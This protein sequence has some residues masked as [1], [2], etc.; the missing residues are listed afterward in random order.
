VSAVFELIVAV[1]LPTAAGFALL[2]SIR[3]WR[4]TAE[5]RCR[6]PAP[7]PISR[8]SADLRRLRAE[9]EATETRADLRAKELRLR[10]LRAA[11]LDALALACQRLEISPPPSGPRVPQAEIYR[12]EEALR[13]RGLEVRPAERAC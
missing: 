8:L 13:Q 10:A 7:E 4:W 12:V 11:Y 5:R 3:A 9:L 6:G 1:L 2:G